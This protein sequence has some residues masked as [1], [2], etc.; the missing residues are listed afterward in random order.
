MTAAL[1]EFQENGFT[2]LRGLLPGNEIARIFA[3]IEQVFDQA[4]SFQGKDPS[5]LASADEKYLY[6]KAKHPELKSHCYNILCMLDAIVTALSRPEVIDFGRELYQSP[7]LSGPAQ[8]RIDDSSDDRLLPFHQ[9]LEMVSLLT[10]NCWVPLVD[11]NDEVGTLGVQPGSHKQGLR[12]HH[13]LQSSNEYWSLAP[14]VVDADKVIALDLKAGD[15][16]LFHPFLYHGSLPNKS[17][18]IR[19]TMAA[20]WSEISHAP[21]LRHGEAALVMDRNPD[22]NSPGVDFV[23]RY[24]AVDR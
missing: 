14:G 10:L 22:P 12:K 15:Y 11:V 16:V 23:R 6:L 21:Y 8:I 2:V 1:K 24:L 13:R 18:R 17:D 7:L 20:R 3:D 19:W 4:L 5:E 9:E